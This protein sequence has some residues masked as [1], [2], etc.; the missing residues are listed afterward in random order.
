MH[1]LSRT[2]YCIPL[3]LTLRQ[4]AIVS[5]QSEYKLKLTGPGL[6]LDKDVSEELA[7]RI[8]LLV[9]G[10]GKSELQSLPN[11]GGGTDPA[12][13]AA[14]IAVGKTSVGEY[15]LASGA[16]KIPQKMTVIGQY[17]LETLKKDNFSM[18]EL[19]KGFSDARESAPKN[20]HRDI[21]SAIK[22]RWIA[23]GK[24]DSYY[25]TSTGMKAIAEHFPKKA[26]RDKG[27]KRKP[28]S[29]KNR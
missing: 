27:K 26:R 28:A 16:H 9:L 14:K 25:V 22:S 11:R 23:S 17:I 20:Q 2:L 21:D 29:A 3:S 18:A 8:T 1:Y 10:D 12:I 5:A 6:T 4:E 24:K 13:P 7:N 19:L 15:L